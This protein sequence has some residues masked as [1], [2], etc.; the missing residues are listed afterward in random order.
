LILCVV[1]TFQLICWKVFLHNSDHF[2]R[3]YDNTMGSVSEPERLG[4]GTG[5]TTRKGGENMERKALTLTRMKKMKQDHEPIAVV[6][7]YD[8]P[9]ANLAEQAGVDVIL[10]GDSLGNV[11]LGYESTVP[12]TI[13]DMVYHTRA[14]TRGAPHTF[15]VADMPFA[16]Y[17]GSVDITLR[18][19]AR[20]MQEGLAKAIKMEGGQEIVPSVEAC[21]RAGIPVMAHIG[22][23]PQSINQIG[24]YRV[25]GKNSKQAQKLL[26]DALALQTAGAFAI[27]LELVTEEIAELISGELSIPTIG[28]GAGPKC[29][30]QVLVFHDL[31]GYG[32]DIIKKKFVKEFAQIGDTIRT[33]ISAYVQEV[34]Q[35]AFPSQDHVFHI[36]EKSEL[37]PLYGGGSG[38]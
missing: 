16:T 34:K 14:V 11:V 2:G 32:G 12:V 18:H 22:L 3:Y 38:K 9:S 4:A 24:G 6:T 23:T 29:D 28:I 36:E 26:N 17:H 21:V 27:V 1:R 10:V 15:I 25:Q 30:G 35:R 19:A 31:L 37:Q 8:Y 33:G 13:D 7:A 5:A 20:L